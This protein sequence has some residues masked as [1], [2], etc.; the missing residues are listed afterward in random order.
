MCKRF[1]LYDLEFFCDLFGVCGPVPQVNLSY[2][3]SPVKN[4]CIICS[5][6]GNNN[7]NYVMS[8]KWGID[9][10]PKPDSDFSGQKKY[11]VINTRDDTL[12]EGVYLFGNT[13]RCLIPANG[14]YE[15]KSGGLRKTPFYIYASDSPVFAFAGV[16]KSS[17]SSNGRSYSC[18]IVTTASNR[19][20]K[21]VHGRMPVI[22]R[23]SGAMKWIN[24]EYEDFLSLLKPYPSE[25]TGLYP[26]GN[27]VENPD[28]DGPKLMERIYENRWW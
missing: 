10:S 11:S 5:N 7:G 16:Y 8:A 1:A 28:N 15:W 21:E 23:G 24:P 25:K 13:G 9:K 17:S 14:F 22:L 4:V 2:N 19:V 6:K 26:V 3:I 18:S 27:G 20:L 12:K